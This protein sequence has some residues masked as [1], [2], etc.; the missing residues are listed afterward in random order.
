VSASARAGGAG[1]PEPGTVRARGDERVVSD[2]GLA[3][4]AEDLFVRLSP[5]EGPA[6]RD[7]CARIERFAALMMAASE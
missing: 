3:A 6:F 4:R 5:Y 7:H 1:V 2:D